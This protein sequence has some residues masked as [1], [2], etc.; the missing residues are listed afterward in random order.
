MNESLHKSKPEKDAIRPDHYGGDANPFEP[1]K[2]INYYKLGFN[3]GN[4]IKY[5]LRAGKKDPSKL[6]EDLEK[7]RQYLDFEI[8]EIKKSQERDA[9]ERC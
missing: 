3:I 9:G 1:I 7:A 2:I 5:I 8:A 4:V 6:L